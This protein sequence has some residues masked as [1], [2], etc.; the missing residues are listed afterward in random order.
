MG[1]SLSW[2][3]LFLVTKGTPG[4]SHWAV[5]G[6]FQSASQRR[7]AVADELLVSLVQWIQEQLELGMMK[8]QLVNR[9]LA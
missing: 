2:R 4:R 7:Q 8:D 5:R 9:L 6:R 1:V 3:I